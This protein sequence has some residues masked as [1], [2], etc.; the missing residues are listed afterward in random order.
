MDTTKLFDC[1]INGSLDGSRIRHVYLR[2]DSSEV[3]SV[4]ERLAFFSRFSS[5]C[6]IQVCKHD[7]SYASLGQGEADFFSNTTSTLKK[8][9]AKEHERDMLRILTPVIRA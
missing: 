7:S 5:S 8:T 9:S 2:T 1:K 4:G 6:C 3:T